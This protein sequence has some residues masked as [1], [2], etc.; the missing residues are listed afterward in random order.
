MSVKSALIGFCFLLL[1]LH[2]ARP[3]PRT[4][5]EDIRLEDVVQNADN[6]R[7][8]ASIRLVEKGRKE[9]ARSRFERAARYFSKAIEIDVNNPFTY[10]YYGVL[11]FRTRQFSQAAELFARSASFFD[12]LDLWQA[13]AWAYRGESLEN[14]RNFSKARKAYDKAMDIDNRNDRAQRGLS[15]IAE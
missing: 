5:P 14:L 1:F 12:D 13:E 6:P 3:V 10:F 11:R 8:A 15:R 7:R 4:I 9:L 2:C